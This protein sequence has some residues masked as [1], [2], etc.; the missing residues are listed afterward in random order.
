MDWHPDRLVIY[1]V[2][3]KLSPEENHHTKRVDSKHISKKLH[4]A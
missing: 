3:V 1:V 2:W 4:S